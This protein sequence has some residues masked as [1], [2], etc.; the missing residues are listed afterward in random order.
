LAMAIPGICECRINPGR[1]ASNIRFRIL[2]M[3]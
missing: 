1:G 2:E 3:R